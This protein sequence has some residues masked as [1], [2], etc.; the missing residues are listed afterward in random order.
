MLEEDVDGLVHVSDISWDKNY[1]WPNEDFKKGQDLEVVVL[2]I[3][4]DN[5]KF[6]LGMKQLSDNPFAVMMRQ[7]PIGKEVSG[8]IEAV[9]EK[10][11]TFRIDENTMGFVPAAEAGVAKS[12]VKESFN[13]GAEIS[14]QI[15]KYDD[16]ERRMIASIKSFEK[17][18]E[19]D[20]MKDFLNKQGDSSVTLQ[21]LMK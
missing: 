19:K 21:D 20:N 7:F 9:D 4:R 11:I 18:Q 17:K 15:K 12:K 14:A 8:K 1:K 16:R 2:N 6:S 13:V 3:D 5:K 10:G